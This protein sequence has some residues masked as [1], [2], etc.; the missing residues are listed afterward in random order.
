MADQDSLNLGFIGAGDICRTRHLPGL[1]NIPGV[2]VVAVCNRTRASS[3]A[4]AA[5]FGIAAIE[6]NWR[7]LLGRDDVDGVFIGTWPYM[8][9]EIS[10]A[11]LEAGKHVF[12]QAR[13]CMDL[14]EARQMLAAA[15]ARPDLV[16]MICP[17]PT[18]MPFEPWVRKAIQEG[19]LGQITAIELIST[20]GANL[21]R[22]SLHW[23][24]CVDYSGKQAM[25]MGI[26]AETLNAWVGPYEELSARISIPIATKTDE[27]GKEA[28][29]GVPQVVHIT[30]KLESGPLAL[31]RH[32]GIVVD[33]TT[34]SNQ[35][36]VWGLEG[37]I[38]YRFGDMIEY[39]GSGEALAP[40]DVPADM[41]RDWM[42]EQDFIDAVRAA[43][44]GVL[45]GDRRVSP[46]FAEGL[47]YMQKVE[48]VHGAASS[49]QSIKLSEL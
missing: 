16:N 12:C 13:M 17:P 11:A 14:A 36:T 6:E 5:D 1:A 25:A 48:A 35:L 8:H 28:S 15:E 44:R 45:P 30:G 43:R 4:V 32:M 23:R 41:Q 22:Q 49:G 18:R 31:E 7:R 29:I 21:N 2:S 47:R 38:R 10:I 34:T 39:A 33:R 26:Y 37:T 19:H 40:V 24:E 46:D 3:E 27:E 42:V 20:S 9:R